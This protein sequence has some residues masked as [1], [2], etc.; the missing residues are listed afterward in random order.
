MPHLHA[1]QSGPCRPPSGLCSGRRG[2]NYPAPRQPDKEC[3]HIAVLISRSR[4]SPSLSLRSTG[5]MGFESHPD[6]GSSR[7]LMGT[8]SRPLARRP[9]A[10]PLAP[11]WVLTLQHPSQA[12]TV[13]PPTLNVGSGPGRGGGERRLGPRFQRPGPFSAPCAP[14]VCVGVTPNRP[15]LLECLSCVAPVLWDP[16]A[17]RSHGTFRRTQRSCAREPASRSEPAHARSHASSRAG[18]ARGSREASSHSARRGRRE[19]R[20][21]AAASA[22]CPV[23]RSPSRLPLSGMISAAAPPSRPPSRPCAPTGIVTHLSTTFRKGLDT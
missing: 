9:L 4:R 14:Q 15:L 3:T 17:P 21:A 22:H 13:V 8:E 11:R 18:G 19:P 2:D 6:P 1:L 10:P 7:L 12:G 23:S 16:K 5:P 20:C